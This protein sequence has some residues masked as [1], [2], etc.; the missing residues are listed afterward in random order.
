MTWEGME[1]T[2][3]YFKMKNDTKQTKKGIVQGSARPRFST[4]I[5]TPVL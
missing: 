2:Q 3:H 1:R 5:Q 4:N